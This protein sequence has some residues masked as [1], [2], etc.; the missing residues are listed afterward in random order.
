[1]QFRTLVPVFCL[2]LAAG[3][4]SAQP[5]PIT[6]VALFRVQPDRLE[7]FV[8]NVHIVTSALD[9]LMQAGTIDAYGLDTDVV[10]G[11]GPNVALWY[12]T[13]NFAGL[14]EGDKAVQGALRANA[15]KAREVWAISDFDKH[16]D[17]I[18]RSL[19]SGGGKVPAG[20]LPVTF[21]QME[22]VKPGKMPVAR[23]MFRHH[24]M[25]VLDQL[26][27]D[28]VIYSYQ[29]NVEAVHTMEPGTVW[30]LILAPGLESMDRIRSAFAASQEKMSEA[31]RRAL[32]AMEEEVFDR[33]AHRDSV[34]RALIFRSR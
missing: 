22:K 17:L 23:M 1:M 34:S 25:P 7:R 13:R 16:R 27:R 31:D 14:A 32:E 15:D 6:S 30:F 3:S 21:F 2:L 12:E 33:K 5:A 28:G 19:E 9:R 10:H 26:V 20:A 29:M 8:D 4:V 11:D 24:D 18:V